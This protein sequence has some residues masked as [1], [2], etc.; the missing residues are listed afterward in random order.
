[1]GFKSVLIVDDIEVL[2]DSYKVLDGISMSVKGGELLAIIG[3]NGAGKTTLLRTIASI[4]KPHRGVVLIDNRNIHLLKPREISELIAYV[5]TEA[6]MVTE[7]RVSELLLISRLLRVNRYWETSTDINVIDKV[8]KL[9]NIEN[10]K[11]R[12]LSELSSGER[13]RVFIARALVQEP[14]ILL[15]DEPTSHLD[16][17]YSAEIMELI[18]NI[19]HSGLIVIFTTHDVNTASIYA[20]KIIVLKD[21]KVRAMGEPHRI[22]SEDLIEDVYGVKVMRIDAGFIKTPLFIPYVEAR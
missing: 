22:L 6:G 5:P 4:L 7:I 2:L 17:H 20:D 1:M 13:Q 11:S 12:K 18:R 14:R 9:L 15:L 10:L 16:L 3:P 19:A 8:L 21:G